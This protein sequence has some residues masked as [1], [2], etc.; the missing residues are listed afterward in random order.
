M[1]SL[2]VVSM[3]LLPKRI[4][5]L[6]TWCIILFSFL[7]VFPWDSEIAELEGKCKYNF[8]K[9]YQNPAQRSSIILHTHQQLMR[10]PPSPQSCQQSRLSSSGFLPTG[11]SSVRF[12]SVQSLSRARLFATPWI[13]AHQASLSITNSGSSLR[14]MS[15]ESVMPSSYL[16]LSVAIICNLFYFERD[17]IYLQEFKDHFYF[18]ELPV[19]MFA[20]VSVLFLLSPFLED[21]VHYESYIANMFFLI[22]IFLTSFVIFFPWKL[23]YAFKFVNLFA[24]R[25]WFIV[26]EVFLHI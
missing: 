24:S 12:S 26:R 16:I 6:I 20:R 7:Q 21:I 1:R 14:L 11:R 5:Q 25:F 19:H 22:V 23:F 18:C 9:S 4:L 3:R 8:A 13:A 2:G 10:M 17:W 15:I